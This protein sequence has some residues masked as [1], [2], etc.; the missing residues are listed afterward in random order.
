MNKILSVFLSVFSFFSHGK[1]IPQNQISFNKERIIRYFNELVNT[2]K[3][4]PGLQYLVFNKDGI[5]LEYA[6][7]YANVKD[8]IKMTS[9]H[10]FSM[11]STTKL[12]TAIAILQLSEKKKL[13]LDETIEKYIADI[14]Y[15]DVTIKHVLSHTG[16]IPN[17][18]IGNFYI[19][20]A[21]EHDYFDR[22]KLLAD[23]MS[24]N[25]N[26]LFKAGTNFSYS[27]L[28]FAILGRIIEIVS[29]KKYEDYVT[30]NIFNRL[31]L[32]KKEINFLDRSY[33]NSAKPYYLENS[34]SFNMLASLVIKGIEVKSEDHYKT[35]ESYWYFNFPSHGGIVAS[36]KEYAKIFIDLLKDHPI[37]LSGP[38]K[39][40]FFTGQFKTSNREVAISWFI[41]SLN[42]KKYYYHQGGGIGYISEVRIYKGNG[43]GTILVINQSEPSLLKILNEIDIELIK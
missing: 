8:K 18:I 3:E 33:S 17:P 1:T 10:T 43:I 2:N 4:Y 35:L 27:N 34:I 23:V 7:G 15:R 26:V 9:D 20:W 38:M 12:I 28:G 42:G 21:K 19:H 31:K 39:E 36:S 22:N 6:G 25:N 32:N 40:L 5:V 24:A 11:F 37:V 13:D 16:G 41:K 14:P 29:G 30:E